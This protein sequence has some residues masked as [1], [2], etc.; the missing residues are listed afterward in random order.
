M[1]IP[2]LPKR[3]LRLWTEAKGECCDRL[4]ARCDEHV[5]K[6]SIQHIGPDAFFSSNAPFRVQFCFL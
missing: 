5:C 3:K 1:D 4:A 2:A 6:Q